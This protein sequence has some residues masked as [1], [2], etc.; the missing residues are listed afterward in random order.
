MKPLLADIIKQKYIFD[1]FDDNQIE[2]LLRNQYLQ[3]YSKNVQYGL[4]K[5]ALAAKQILSLRRGLYLLGEHYRRNEI[6]LFSIAMQ[7]C[8]PSYISLESALSYHRMIPEAVYTTTCLTSKRSVEY[9]NELGVFSY[10]QIPLRIFQDG[11]VRKE[12][13]KN[14]FFI[15]TP[16]KALL[17]LIFVR[18]KTYSNIQSLYQDLRI[19]PTIFEKFRASELKKLAKLYKRKTVIDFVTMLLTLQK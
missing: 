1:F 7:I 10:Q 2:I 15:A 3:H 8:A 4:V 19:E 14:I 16:E 12:E 13:N 17:D 9:H 11:V 18:R 5:R 6:N